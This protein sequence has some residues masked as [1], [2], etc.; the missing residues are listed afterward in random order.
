M[1]AYLLEHGAHPAGKPLCSALKAEDTTI[2]V[3]KWYFLPNPTIA[4]AFRAYISVGCIAFFKIL[5]HG[6]FGRAWRLRPLDEAFYA[7]PGPKA[8]PTVALQDSPR[9]QKLGRTMRPQG[10]LRDVMKQRYQ[11][12]YDSVSLVRNQK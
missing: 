10:L 9:L 7:P 8:P 5:Y 2:F 12:P 11:P 4:F 1:P 6:R 3:D